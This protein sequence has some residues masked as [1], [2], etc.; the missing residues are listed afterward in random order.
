[1]SNLPVTTI[2]SVHCNT[3]TMQLYFTVRPTCRPRSLPIATLCLKVVPTHIIKH[4]L[5]LRL[6]GLGKIAKD[7]IDEFIPIIDELMIKYSAGLY[8]SPE[9]RLALAVG[10]VVMTVH[11][12]NS[13]DPRLAEAVKRVSQPVKK[14]VGADK[15]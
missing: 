14:P 10:S 5:N 11:S 12:A 8:V 7:N 9:A 15:M 1:M 4:P 13:G 2:S 3:D 6:E